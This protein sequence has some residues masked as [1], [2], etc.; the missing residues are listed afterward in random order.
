M[1]ESKVAEVV[2]IPVPI[3][4]GRISLRKLQEFTPGTFIV[5]NVYYGG[6]R[7]IMVTIGT[8]SPGEIF[9]WIKNCDLQGR[10]FYAFASQMD[11]MRWEKHRIKKV[12]ELKGAVK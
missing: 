10:L 11:Y 5:S 12:W 3:F 8:K 4:S 9:S 2:R 6:S 7:Q 1:Q